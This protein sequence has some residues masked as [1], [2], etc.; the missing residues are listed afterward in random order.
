MAAKAAAP[1]IS[2][3]MIM[4]NEASESPRVSGCSGR[5][6][7][8]S[9][10]STRRYWNGITT[11]VYDAADRTTAVQYYHGLNLSYGYDA[12][13]NRL[14]LDDAKAGRTTYGYDAQN[15]VT[16][17]WNPFNERTTIAWDA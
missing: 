14:T 3:C 10:F 5:A 15:R 16:L 1:E 8:R 13:G 9:S 17:I 12:V 6:L 11:N 2:L 4:R 7:A